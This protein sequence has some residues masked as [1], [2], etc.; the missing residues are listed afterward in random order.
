[1]L[2]LMFKHLDVKLNAESGRRFSTRSIDYAGL[3]EPQ[4]FCHK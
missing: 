2:F 3:V 4:T 1:M